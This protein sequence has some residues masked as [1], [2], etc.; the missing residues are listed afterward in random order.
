MR[1]TALAACAALTALAGAAPAHAASNFTIK[2]A[3]YGHGVGMSQF[4]ALGLA[5]GRVVRALLRSPKTASFTG[6]TKAGDRAL[7]AGKVYRVTA[8][9]DGTMV[10]RSA[11]NRRLATFPAPLQVTGDGPLTLRGPATNGIHKNGLAYVRGLSSGRS[12]TSS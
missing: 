6:A 5:S 4:G 3:G 11:T 9:L 2:G 12:A 8:Q 10:L 1:R 7:H